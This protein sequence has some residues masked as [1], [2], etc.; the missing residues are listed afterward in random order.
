MIFSLS[1]STCR[2]ASSWKAAT[3]TSAI[4]ST[5][6]SEALTSIAQDAGQVLDHPGERESA[7]FPHMEAKSGPRPCFLLE[8]QRTKMFKQNLPHV[9]PRL[10]LSV[11]ISWSPRETGSNELRM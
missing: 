9:L 11:S 4:P 3:I 1:S 2:V 8:K 10:V 7:P 5:S 6:S